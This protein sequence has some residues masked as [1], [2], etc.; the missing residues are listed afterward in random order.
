MQSGCIG[1]WV[2]C[3][4]A[5]SCQHRHGVLEHDPLLLLS[6]LVH[7]YSCDVNKQWQ[8]NLIL[9]FENWKKITYQ[10]NLTH[11]V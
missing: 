11:K 8:L 2:R 7:V 1:V 9:D 4:S 6:G 5:A 10:F 3:E